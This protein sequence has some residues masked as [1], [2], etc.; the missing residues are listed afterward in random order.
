MLQL[1][2]E[3]NV[4]QEAFLVDCLEKYLETLIPWVFPLNVL[5]QYDAQLPG[6]KQ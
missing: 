4:A 2:F 3:L 5:Q 1:N 6:N